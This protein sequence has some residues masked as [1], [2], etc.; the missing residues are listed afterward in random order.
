MMRSRGRRG[1]TLI[2]ILIVM[3]IIGILARVALPEVL[4]VRLKARSARIVTDMELI[5]GAAFNVFADSG[6]WPAAA[7]AGT[8]PPSMSAYLPPSVSFTPEPGTL[9]EW[10]MTGIPGGDQG[11]AE[12]GAT[13]GMGAAV[14]DPELRV[15]LQRSLSHHETLVAGTTTYWLL[16]GVTSRP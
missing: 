4:R 1:F 8:M 15:E 9:Y 11:A 3:T 7:A 2:E 6:Y 16:W 12:A 14:E 10:R 13:M 5:R